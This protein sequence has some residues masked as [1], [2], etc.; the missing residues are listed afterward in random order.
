MDPSI[1]HLPIVWSV[2][3]VELTSS[4]LTHCTEKWL[5]WSQRTHLRIVMRSTSCCWN[6]WNSRDT[7]TVQTLNHLSLYIHT[8]QQYKCNVKSWSHVSWDPR[9]V[10][11]TQKNVFL[12]NFEQKCANIP[13]T[14]HFS[15][16]KIIHP[17]DRCGISRSWL[18]STII[19]Q[20]HL[21]LGTIKG[22]SKMCR[23]VTTQCHRCLKFWGSV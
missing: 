18:N 22:H 15:F 11:N 2:V 8:E 19:T 1:I 13:V 23:F 4:S 6:T 10:P 14:E 3:I 16:A 17:P 5:Q 12:S 21:V 20:V 7:H 9:N